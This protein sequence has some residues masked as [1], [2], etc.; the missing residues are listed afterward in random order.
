MTHVLNGD[1]V[2]C[3]LKELMGILKGTVWY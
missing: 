3:L 2:P 1:T